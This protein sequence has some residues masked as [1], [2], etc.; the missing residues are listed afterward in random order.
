MF[1]FKNNPFYSKILKKVLYINNI[2]QI[3]NR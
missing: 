2:I 3:K 1:I